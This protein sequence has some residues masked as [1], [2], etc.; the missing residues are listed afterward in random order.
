MEQKKKKS[1]LQLFS[2]PLKSRLAVFRFATS[3]PLPM[4][5]NNI[6]GHGDAVTGACECVC[7]RWAGGYRSVRTLLSHSVMIKALPGTPYRTTSQLDRNCSAMQLVLYTVS[8]GSLSHMDIGTHISACDLCFCFLS[9]MQFFTLFFFLY[10]TLCFHLLFQLLWFSIPTL[11]HNHLTPSAP[12]LNHLSVSLHF[13]L[14]VCVWGEYML[15]HNVFKFISL[16]K[17]FFFY[18]ILLFFPHCLS[19]CSL[20]HLLF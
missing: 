1:N 18:S 13:S 15:L 14:C 5:R 9:S 4:Y 11:M 16:C 10:I 12:V 19:S 6:S 3:L 8:T 2:R 17:V 7:V 20:H